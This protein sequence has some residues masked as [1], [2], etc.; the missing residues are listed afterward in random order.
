MKRY[1]YANIMPLEDE[2]HD[3]LLELAKSSDIT[4]E[5]AE[6]LAT[7]QLF[8]NLD[9]LLSL[10]FNPTVPQAIK[11][12]MK[13]SK[14]VI[15]PIEQ[16]FHYGYDS[17]ED[18]AYRVCCNDDADIFVVDDPYYDKAYWYK[19]AIDIIDGFEN[20]APKLVYDIGSGEFNASGIMIKG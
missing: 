4:V 9:I 1:I 13:V 6:A 11:D 15:I 3:A 12:T 5:Q 7:M 16:E 19:D 8:N 20:E 14:Y 18:W 10:Y 2:D 17:S